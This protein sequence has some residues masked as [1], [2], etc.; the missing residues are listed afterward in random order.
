[1]GHFVYY[2]LPISGLLYTTL[3][4]QLSLHIGIFVTAIFRQSG[5]SSS[6]QKERMMQKRLNKY[7]VSDN[8]LYYLRWPGLE[9][10]AN[11]SLVRLL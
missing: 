5:R 2:C 3:G 9:K 1:M 6:L 4:S 10:K 8:D 11:K 7:R